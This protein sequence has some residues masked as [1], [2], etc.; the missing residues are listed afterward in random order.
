MQRSTVR[1]LQN[2]ENM[3]TAINLDSYRKWPMKGKQPT[4]RRLI[5]KRSL[6][7]L[8]WTK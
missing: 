6:R 7:L 5:L 2:L 3:C 4:V 1:G 8:S